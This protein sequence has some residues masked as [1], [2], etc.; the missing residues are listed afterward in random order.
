MYALATIPL[1]QSLKSNILQVWYADDA[2]AVGKISLLC[3]WWDKLSTI[4]PSFGYL[5]N[6]SKTWLITKDHHLDEAL[7]LASLI[8]TSTSPPKEDHTL[9]LRL[10]Q[11]AS[12]TSVTKKVKQWTTE[13]NTLAQ[14]VTTHL[15]ATFSRLHSW[16]D[17]QM[18]LSRADDTQHQQQPAVS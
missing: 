5:A 17:Q 9:V 16:A 15:H 14:F 10:V 4:A 6:P 3:D 18:V 7:S 8:L 13:V 12:Q 11:R 2:S 1:I